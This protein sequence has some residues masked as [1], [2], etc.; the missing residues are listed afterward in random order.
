MKRDEDFLA[1][2]S[3]LFLENGAKTVTMDDIAKELGVSK[4]TLYQKYKN[5]ESLLEEVLTYALDKVLTRM[6]NLDEEIDN[7]IDRMLARDQ[8]VEKASRTN[9]SILLRQLI[10]YY[11]GIFTKHMQNF[12]EKFADILEQN[13]ARGRKQ[14]YYRENFDSRL[15]AKLFFQLIITYD[16]SPYLETKSISRPEYHHEALLF[17]MNSIAT[18]K[19]RKYIEKVQ[20]EK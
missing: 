6:R 13:I 4:K 10:K 9:D 16:N 15:Y 5:K 3:T 17:Y 18:E 2:V 12:A 20:V 14:G 19:G 11:P 1:K 8:E 7:A